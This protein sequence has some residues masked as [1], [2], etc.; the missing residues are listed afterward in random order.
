[1]SDRSEMFRGGTRL[2]NLD[3]RTFCNLYSIY[4][5]CV[6]PEADTTREHEQAAGHNQGAAAEVDAVEEQQLQRMQSGSSW[7]WPR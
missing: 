5:T 7:V 4:C 6:W 2:V 1:M 3:L